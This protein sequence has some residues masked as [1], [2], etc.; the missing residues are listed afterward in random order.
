[1]SSNK[2]FRILFYTG[3]ILQG[4]IL[5]L[6]LLVSVNKMFTER[7]LSNAIRYQAF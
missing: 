6:L 3:A 7:D 4:I 1:M 2:I 5:A